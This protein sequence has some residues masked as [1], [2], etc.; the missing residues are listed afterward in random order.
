M[1]FSRASVGKT[2]KRTKDTI[3]L[4]QSLSF[5]FEEMLSL[6]LNEA[7]KKKK[8]EKRERETQSQWKLSQNDLHARVDEIDKNVLYN[9][10][11][12]IIF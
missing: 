8:K 2:I 4:K 5:I 7:T 11:R 10:L 1:I 12:N 9:H 6:E 3:V